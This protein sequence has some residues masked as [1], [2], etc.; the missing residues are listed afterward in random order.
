MRA[1]RPVFLMPAQLI[2]CL[3]W[4]YLMAALIASLGSVAFGE[5][6]ATEI[7]SQHPTRCNLSISASPLGEAL[8]QLAQHCGLQ[9]A[10]LSDVGTSP[11]MVG[12]VSGLL[13]REEALDQ[14]L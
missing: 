13:T 8:P 4:G 6:P 3:A 12:P 9:F 14:L 11:I 5:S 2:R 1:V 10:R 7:A